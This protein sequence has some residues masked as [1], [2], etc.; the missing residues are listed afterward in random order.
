MAQVKF[1]RGT[2]ERY[3]QLIAGA[4][5]EEV[6][7]SVYFVTDDQV[8][9]MNEK[10][11]GGATGTLFDGFVKNL[12]VEGQTLKFNKSVEGKDTEISIKLIDAADKSIVIG[13]IVNGKVKDGSNIKVNIKNVGDV[14]GLKL[15]SGT[16]DNGLYVDLTKTT[17]AITTN[18]T[19]IANE[20]TRAK[21]A[22]E[23]NAKAITILNANAATVGSVDNKIDTAIKGL[24]VNSI[25]G[26]GKFIQSVKEEKG[27]ITAVEADLTAAAVA[28]DKTS[29]KV[30]AKAT[31]VSAA[32]KE[33]DAKVAANKDAELTYKTVKLTAEEITALADVNVKEA[34]KVVSVD[35]ASKETTVGDVIKI[36]KDSAL[37]SIDYTETGENSKKGQFLKYVYTLADGAEKTVYVD[38]SKLVDQAE[39]EN[40]IQAVDGKLSIKLADGNEADFLTVGANGLKLSGVKTAIDTA[41]K[42][43]QD[44][45][46]AEITRAKGAEKKNADA[47]GVNADAITVLNGAD[48]VKGSVAKSV[49]DAKKALLGDAAEGYNTLGKLEDKIQAVD[50]K[51]SSAH[52]E[53]VAKTDGHVTVA[54]VDS[55]DG[56]HKVVTISENDIAS[57][58]ALTDE[59]TRAKNEEDKIEASVGLAADGSH[60]NATGNY[61]SGATTVVGEIAALDAQVKANADAIAANAN[62]NLNL[63]EVGGAGKVITT[64][65]QKNGQV[66]ATA[67]DLV[68]SAVTRTATDDVTGKTVEAALSELA[69]AIKAEAKAREGADTTISGNVTT[70]TSDITE[71]KKTVSGHTTSINTLNGKETADGSVKHTAKG[72]ADTALT[73]AKAYTD[74]ALNWIDAG[75]YGA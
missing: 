6:K 75:T 24:D 36:Y 27:V 57:A 10:Q 5:S 20:V 49:A 35:K 7:N 30:I 4:K 52:T 63:T 13:D 33:L 58:K 64:V 53:V 60:V 9:M 44:N 47:I 70:N 43:V 72:Y 1:I 51:A 41:Q 40:G 12:D 28:Y 46:D 55:K 73:N 54:V 31:D 68:A 42:A 45:L 71:L 18:A 21:K 34:Y 11:Y 56:T 17:A 50:A 37:V 69:T 39:V 23:A 14:D 3:N 61:T 66:S 59:V 38:M 62:T 16:T 29:D 67:I 65:S 15:D 8:I 48:T 25:G 22:E 19:D 32:I 26:E 2:R 74:E